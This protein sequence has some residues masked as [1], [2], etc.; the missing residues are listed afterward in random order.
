MTG[1]PTCALPISNEGIQGSFEGVGIQYQ[2]L[3]DTLYVNQTIDGAPSEK[4]G[5]Q[6]GDRIIKVDTTIIAGN[7]TSTKNIAKLLRG[8]KGTTV[9]VLVS[10]RNVP[11]PILFRITRDKIPIHSVDAAYMIEP[12]IG[13]IKL[14][15]FST[16][17]T[18]EMQEA[19][20]KL[21]KQKMRK[22]ILDLQGNGG[23]I[24]EAAINLV[25]DALADRKLIVYTEGEHL[26][27]S[28]AYS[29]GNGKLHKIDLIV[30]VDDYSA[31]ASEIV[32]GAL[33]DWERATIIGRRTFGKGLVQSTI[34]LENK[35]QMRLT[36]ARYY[37]PSGR[38][39]QK[40]YNE[41]I[42]AYQKDIEKR[43]KHG[44]M[45]YADSVTFPD[46]LKYKTMITGRTV[47]GGGGIWPDIFVPL[48]TTQFT[49][50]HRNVIA[51]GVFNSTLASYIEKNRTLL[52]EKFATVK[53]FNE[54]YLIPEE[55]YQKLIDNA[56]KEDIEY[57]EEQYMR[58]YPLLTRQIKAMVARELYGQEAYYKIMNQENPIVQAALK[59]WKV[60]EE[61]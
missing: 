28:N 41:G 60:G 1:V 37:T 7:K 11:E 59:H 13:Y 53:V 44:E 51:K 25:D 57:N 8:P 40:P 15:S 27:R 50:Y 3:Q 56:T 45:M 10:R 26:P 52:K 23:G 24:M 39:I 22:L 20:E 4:V 18:Q 29:S 48:D 58:S 33:Q 43:L 54:K 31:S 61:E 38:N 47:Y 32:A 46:S 19:I 42:D 49:A 30:L 21:T 35:G 16:T 9:D 55:L 2:M 5:I 34:P 36:V 17:T 14:N 6:P 12:G